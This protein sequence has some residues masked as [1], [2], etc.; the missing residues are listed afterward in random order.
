MTVPLSH[1]RKTSYNR[2]WG[3]KK[4][5]RYV[6]H[7]LTC[8]VACHRKAAEA[9]NLDG[10]AG[11]VPIPRSPARCYGNQTIRCNKQDRGRVPGADPGGCWG[12]EGAPTPATEE[13]A[14]NARF[15]LPRGVERKDTDQCPLNGHSTPFKQSIAINI[16]NCCKSV[17]VQTPMP[18]NVLHGPF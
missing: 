2:S 13:S 11:P 4:N 15:L 5:Q 14:L 1:N 3:S 10:D 7:C 12:G 9:P 16:L 8:F 18:V 6:Q 17:F